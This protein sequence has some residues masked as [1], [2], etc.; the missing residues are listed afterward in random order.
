[1]VV[2]GVDIGMIVEVF[3]EVSFGPVTW[4]KGVLMGTYL[5]GRG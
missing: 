1:M 5:L 3:W 4:F 2:R